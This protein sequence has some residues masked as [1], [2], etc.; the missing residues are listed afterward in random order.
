MILGTRMPAS[1]DAWT[2]VRPTLLLQRESNDFSGGRGSKTG[3]GHTLPRARR[4]SFGSI[5]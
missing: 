5:S 4:S 3:T 2:S 1:I